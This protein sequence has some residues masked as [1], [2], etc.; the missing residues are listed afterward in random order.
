M[1]VNSTHYLRIH[2]NVMKVEKKIKI[3]YTKLRTGGMGN[4]RDK[5]AAWKSIGSLND[6]CNVLFNPQD[7]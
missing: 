5:N 2:I 4:E 7:R 6:I 3:I 1:L